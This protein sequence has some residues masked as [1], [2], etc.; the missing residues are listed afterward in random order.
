MLF[1]G[2]KDS[3]GGLIAF[4]G[5]IKDAEKFKLFC[6]DATKGGSQSEKDGVSF[7]SKSPIVVGW[8]KE[9]FL[10]VK[11]SPEFTYGNYMGG[12]GAMAEKPRDLLATCAN[13]F[14]LKEENSLG[15]NEKFTALVKTPGDIHFWMN[16][17][18]LNKN[19]L[20]AN[21]ALSM[22]KLNDLYEGSF[23][24]ATINFDNGKILVDVKSYAGK[25]MSELYKKY[26]ARILMKT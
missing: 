20:S 26:E 14:N 13:L 2:Q 8:N 25:K 6:L 3:T 10:F 7:I 9:K 18:Q 12:T 11:N 19:M 24:A 22:I 23:T 15:E 16:G 5:T 17:E 21:P 1:F 4:T